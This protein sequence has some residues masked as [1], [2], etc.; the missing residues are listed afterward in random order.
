MQRI[1]QLR[2]KEIRYNIVGKSSKIDELRGRALDIRGI[3][4]NS[5]I[6]ESMGLI[7]A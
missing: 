1:R 4:T 7:G 5:E 2:I 3:P 6:L